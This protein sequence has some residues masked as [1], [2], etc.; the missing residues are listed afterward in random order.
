MALAIGGLLWFHMTFRIVVVFYENVIG[1]LKEIVLILWDGFGQ[2][3]LY[4]VND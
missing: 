4:V 1:V 2:Y 3:G